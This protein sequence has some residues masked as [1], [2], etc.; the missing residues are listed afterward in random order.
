MAAAVS[1][2]DGDCNHS[3]VVA[4]ANRTTTAI[5]EIIG[6]IMGSLHAIKQP[7]RSESFTKNSGKRGT[8]RRS[9]PRRRAALN[10][11]AGLGKCGRRRLLYQTVENDSGSDSNNADD[12]ACDHECA[13][14]ICPVSHNRLNARILPA[15]RKP[16]RDL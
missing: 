16:P 1:S 7:G 12:K 8:V 3:T 6:R 10:S 13:H 9:A 15:D 5:T 11:R 14:R 4:A 2:I